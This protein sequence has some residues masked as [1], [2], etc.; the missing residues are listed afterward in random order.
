MCEINHFK[1]FVLCCCDVAADVHHL[2]I[3]RIHLESLMGHLS[4]YIYIHTHARRIYSPH[5]RSHHGVEEEWF[6]WVRP[7][8]VPYGPMCLACNKRQNSRIRSTFQKMS[9]MQRLIGGK[10]AD[11]F[12]NRKKESMT[13]ME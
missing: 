2:H 3:K 5:T 4:L 12:G 7:V 13:S 11:F 1:A 6:G 10:H 8:L 9:A